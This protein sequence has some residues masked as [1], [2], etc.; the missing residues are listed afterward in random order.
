MEQNSI[1]TGQTFFTRLQEM[2]E[3]SA[4]LNLSYADYQRLLTELNILE[5]E[6]LKVLSENLLKAKNQ[7]LHTLASQIEN[8]INKWEKFTTEFTN[9]LKKKAPKG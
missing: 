6:G 8:N 1:E 4:R 5:R 7:G 2:K 9:Y 3:K